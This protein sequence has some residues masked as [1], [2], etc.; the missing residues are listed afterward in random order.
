MQ[1]ADALLL[2]ALPELERD[3]P[4]KLFDYLAAKRPVLVHGAPGEASRAV[5]ELGA[6]F[7]CEDGNDERLLEIL[8]R[9]RAGTA[10]PQS[11]R[12]ERW[13]EEHRR[14]VLAGRLYALLDELQERSRKRTGS[15]TAFSGRA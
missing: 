3:L 11:D 13:L 9:L 6:G 15:F 7:L 1:Q 5:E 8:G 2:I 14:D 4:G 12:T 10:Q